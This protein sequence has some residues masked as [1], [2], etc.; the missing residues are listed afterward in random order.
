MTERTEQLL[1]VDQVADIVQLDVETIRV[2]IR[3]GELPACKIRRRIRVKPS[4]LA[5][6]IDSTRIEPERLDIAGSLP[7]P[8]VRAPRP[9]GMSFTERAKRAA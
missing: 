1:S 2:A 9:S 5:A 3:A 6:W 7:P 8:P 4:D